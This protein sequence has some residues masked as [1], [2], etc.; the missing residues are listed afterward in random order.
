MTTVSLC[1]RCLDVWTEGHTCEECEPRPRYE[2]FRLRYQGDRRE[3][4]RHMEE[5][6]QRMIDRLDAETRSLQSE[7]TTGVVLRR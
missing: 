5:W 4:L 7:P 6:R 3:A 2:R 1:S